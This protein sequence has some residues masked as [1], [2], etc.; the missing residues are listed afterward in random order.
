MSQVLQTSLSSCALEE[1]SLT[2]QLALFSYKVKS[3]P[4]KEDT[5]HETM[6]HLRAG[7]RSDNQD[8]EVLAS[9]PRRRPE[10]H[11][12][13]STP[14]RPSSSPTISSATSRELPS[15]RAAGL[16][17]SPRQGRPSHPGGGPPEHHQGSQDDTNTFPI[18]VTYR[19]HATF[20]IVG[21]HWTMAKVHETILDAFSKVE[22]RSTDIARAH[23]IHTLRVVWEISTQNL[24]VGC[25]PFPS[26]TI[27]TDDNLRAVL[28]F[29]RR[30]RSDVVNLELD[31]SGFGERR[32]LF[33]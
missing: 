13:P 6:S 3:Q 19:N 27:V 9:E 11:G 15:S 23:R 20:I 22:F 10:Q 29:L 26:N 32:A 25:Y 8:S 21:S 31:F 18:A 5:S 16:L 14:D 28:G 30:K 7:R 12:A 2:R 1:L 33:Q 17:G 4:S 24:P